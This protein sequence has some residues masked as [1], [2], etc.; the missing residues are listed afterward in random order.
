MITT[1]FVAVA[2]TLSFSALSSALEAMLLSTRSVEVEHLKV[3]HPKAGLLLESL[4][5]D[6]E[7]TIASILTINTVANTL[8]SI[9][10]GALSTKAFGDWW[11][12]VVS[13]AMTLSILFFAE[14]LPKN[15][16]VL[17]RPALQPYLV[18]PLY[19]FCRLAGPLTNI[20]TWLIRKILRRPP[21]HNNEGEI[22]LLAEKEALAGRMNAAQLRLIRSSLDFDDVLVQDV[23][24][25]RNVVLTCEATDK[26]GELFDQLEKI[27]FGRIPVTGENPDDI[28]GVLRRKDLLQ[29]LATG[30]TE[31]EVQTLMLTPVIVPEIGKLFSALELLL[32]AH[33]QLAVV[34]NEFGGFAGVLT[35]EDIFEFLIGEEFYESDDVAVDMQEF[36]RR[37]SR[38]ARGRI[39]VE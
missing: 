18:Y 15:I 33:Q 7:G 2:F 39:E 1:F 30:K 22:Q 17:Y 11:L 38:I 24:T 31:T 14:I 3:S 34:V 25:P 29:T 36:A 26:V 5:A 9:V 13:A 35:L 27:R 12:G 23:M 37:R 32:K 4:R 8:G 10:V 19:G 21:E 16:G 20:S 6:M 28:I